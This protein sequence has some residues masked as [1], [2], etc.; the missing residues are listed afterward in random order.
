MGSP[1]SWLFCLQFFDS[2]VY[3]AQLWDLKEAVRFCMEVHIGN[4]KVDHCQLICYVSNF[5][6]KHIQQLTELKTFLVY[7]LCKMFESVCDFKSVQI[8]LNSYGWRVQAS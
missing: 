8:S 5:S 1:Y 4:F 2:I 3:F 6:F 7:F